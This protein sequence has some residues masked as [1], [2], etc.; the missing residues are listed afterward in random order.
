MG[1]SYVRWVEPGRVVSCR[2]DAMY[3]KRT[4]SIDIVYMY[5]SMS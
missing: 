1:P 5:I 4:H 2:N 3:I